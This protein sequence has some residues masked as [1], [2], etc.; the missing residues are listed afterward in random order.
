[1]KPYGIRNKLVR[2]YVNYH[3]KGSDINWWEAETVKVKSKKTARQ[4]ARRDLKLNL[5]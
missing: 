1:M 2:N 4:K 5:S 3:P